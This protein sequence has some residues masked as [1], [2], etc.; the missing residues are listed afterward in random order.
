MGGLDSRLRE[1]DPRAAAGLRPKDGAP[2]DGEIKIP[3]T[4][5]EERSMRVKKKKGAEEM[6]D[7]KIS[8]HKMLRDT[9]IV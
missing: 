5:D 9:L 4:L 1:R 2:D 6:R 8:L 7:W 3:P